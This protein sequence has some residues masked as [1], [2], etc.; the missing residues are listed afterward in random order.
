MVVGGTRYP[1]GQGILEVE[2]GTLEVG[3]PRW[4]NEIAVYGILAISKGGQYE[5]NT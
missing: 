4:Y 2:Q 5:D 3:G 1:R